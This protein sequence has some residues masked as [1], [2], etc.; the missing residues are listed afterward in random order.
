LEPDNLTL[1][2]SSGISYG[3]LIELSASRVLNRELSRWCSPSCRVSEDKHSDAA[4]IDSPPRFCETNPFSEL[5][6]QRLIGMSNRDVQ[7][8][9]SGW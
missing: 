3:L 4:K 5:L 7:L 2:K 1:P 9:D 6:L 8:Y